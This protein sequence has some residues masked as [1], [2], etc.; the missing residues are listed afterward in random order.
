M[1]KNNE[2]FENIYKSITESIGLPVFSVDTQ[3]R[4]T[5]FNKIHAEQMKFLHNADIRLDKS[6]L[7]YFPLAADIQKV[8][9][10]IDKALRGEQWIDE[11]SWGES[12]NTLHYEV[13]HN[14]I[15]DKTG[16]IKG[17][18]FVGRDISNYRN[19]QEKLNQIIQNYNA[20]FQTSPNAIVVTDINGVVKIWNEAAEK[21]FGWK[22]EET[23]G[24]YAS[25]I[26]P[27]KSEEA[28]GV[29]TRILAGETIKGFETVRLDITGKR[30]DVRFSASPF[31]DGHGEISGI[32]AIIEDVSERKAVES[33]LQ[34][35]LQNKL[36]IEH[37]LRDV[38]DHMIEGCQILGKD[39]TYKYLN[40][41][42]V[43]DARMER[44]SLIGRKITECFPDF[45]NTTIYSVMKDCMENRVFR[46][47]YNEFTYEDK[48]RGYFNLSITPIP[49][50]LF[51][52]SLDITKQKL[53]QEA[54][55][56]SENKLK[57]F[58]EYAPAG[59][60]MFDSKL[61]FIAVSQ[62]FLS[63]YGLDKNII[64][65]HQY[66]V[67]PEVPDQWKEI[68][69][70]CLSGATE[71]KEKDLFRRKDGSVDWVRWKITPWFENSSRIGGIVLFSELI[72]EKIKSEEALEIS[73]KNFETAFESNPSAIVI[74]NSENK[75]VLVNEAFTSI[76]GYTKEEV[77][78][79]HDQD[80]STFVDLSIRQSLK[81]M[82]SRSGYIKNEEILVKTKSGEV[83]TVII[84]A[85]P[86]ILSDE[87]CVLIS[88]VDITGL[89][90]A[91]EKQRESEERFSKIFHSS[92]VGINIFDLETGFSMDVNPAFLDMIGYSRDEVIG[93][94]ADEM[95]LFVRSGSRKIWVDILKQGSGVINQD[96]AIR[97]KNGE[98][99]Y[100][101]V[102]IEVIEI[103]GR[104][105]G[106]VL[107][108]DITDRKIA[109]DTIRLREAE[110]RNLNET[111]E[112]SI[113]ERTA[114]VMD[115]YN[116]SPCGYHSLNKDSVF[117]MVNDTELRWLAYERDELINKMKAMDILTPKS[118]ETFS[119]NFPIFMKTG[120][121]ND[122]E[123]DFI[124]K[125]GSILSVLLNATAVYDD[126]GGFL[127]SRSTM[128]DHTARKHA[129]ESLKKALIRLEEANK[130]LE[131]FSYSV[132]HDLRAPLRAI[133]GFT[134]ILLEDYSPRF[135]EEGKRI[136]DVIQHNSDMMGRLIDD[137]LAF[138]RFGR[139]EMNKISIPMHRIV[140]SVI[141]ELI[142]PQLK[143]RTEIVMGELPEVIID[144]SLMK[145]V[146][147]NLI[148]NAIK[149]SSG[150]EQTIIGITSVIHYDKVVFSI[151]DNGIGFDMMYAD[152]LFGVFQRLHSET[153]FEGT[154]VGLA[155]VKRIINRH[156]G[157]IWA[158]SRSGEGSVFSF[159]IPK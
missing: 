151:R 110:L 72:T 87:N 83:K 14:P 41:A 148:S 51:V 10:N 39:W 123:L 19:T 95:N 13:T 70:R 118:Q 93:H 119:N 17:A 77:T 158:E 107:A 7:D 136:C 146:W 133:N 142:T 159:S 4:Y 26:P 99:R 16:K 28:I 18:V 60:A 20:V 126:N 98:I 48:S 38:M 36:K 71:S 79:K 78:G 23:I 90:Q 129:E 76:L 94:S 46:N 53:A 32:I 66:E 111:L 3:Y 56:I 120:F 108:T 143:R 82:L 73:R 30:I 8:K 134:Q 62:R 21:I 40:D 67:F 140:Q 69:K 22:K 58:V 141:D 45:E 64:G 100:A 24:N 92:P 89:K 102:S 35:S 131:S 121:L 130:E 42:A 149:Y 65:R 11:A 74:V 124:R 49:D 91:Q 55:Q 27:D 50:G 43:R 34:Q 54:L 125:D 37:Q 114:E 1:E 88:F 33:E 145:Q 2:P 59:I 96:A 156:G 127:R 68:H 157:D 29:R 5:S 84:S 144:P 104:K 44:D 47:V 109:E 147:V 63:D 97:R 137:L 101:M 106:L 75:F 9:F 6:I 117:E 115:L 25:F 139:S 105:M 128:I 61:N 138:S 86:I 15:Y 116:N 52:L 85:R 150:K 122:L 103:R 152:K 112:Q 31:R 57:L 80:I 154:G 113:A 155:I 81:E 132:S 153:E 135:D 12:P